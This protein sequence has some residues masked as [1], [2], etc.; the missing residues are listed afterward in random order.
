MKK[1][2]EKGMEEEQGGIKKL[3]T[4]FLLIPHLGVLADKQCEAGEFLTP[5]KTLKNH[6]FRS[7]PVGGPLDCHLLCK[8]D[9]KC[10]SY[11]FVVFGNICELNN[12]TKEASPRDLVRDDA[13][14]YMGMKH[15]EGQRPQTFASCRDIYR[16][17]RTEVNGNYLLQMPSGKVSVYCHM[18]SQGLGSCSGGGWTLV[19]K[20]DGRK[21]TFHY[22]SV[23]WSNT[24][25]FNLTSGETGFDNYETKLPTYWKTPFDKICLGMKIGQQKRFIVVHKKAISLHSLIADG[26]YRNTSL[27]RGTWK[28]LLGGDASLQSFCNMEGFNVVDLTIGSFPKTKARIGLIANEVDHCIGCDSRIGF[29]TGGDPFDF[30]VCGN[31]ASWNPREYD[32]NNKE[33]FC[34]ILVQ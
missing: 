30:N 29:G 18:S 24:E 6:H 4:L 12:S 34:Y 3:F 8:K 1:L 26:Q 31:S 11:N 19:M 9:P 33:A 32:R 17:S 2:L 23:L 13:R 5:E 10:Q 16:E 25:S 15:A 28:S 21:Q 22:N 20:I 7:V 14:F 27:G